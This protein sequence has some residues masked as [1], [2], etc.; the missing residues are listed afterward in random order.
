MEDLRFPGA[1][2]PQGPTPTATAGK[3]SISLEMPKIPFPFWWPGINSYSLCVNTGAQAGATGGATVCAI[4]DK[5]G[6]A[7][8]E[9]NSAGAGPGLG[10]GLTIGVGYSTG[11]IDDQLGWAGY[12]DVGGKLGGDVDASV[13]GNGRGV[14]TVNLNVGI[15]AGESIGFAGAGYTSI[16]ARGTY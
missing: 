1:K 13:S 3:N 2:A 10:G 14:V 11:T 7:I 5:K 15:Y 12:V 8:I 9:T 6:W 16:I 4:I